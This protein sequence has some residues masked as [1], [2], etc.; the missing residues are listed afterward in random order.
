[1]RAG[2]TAEADRLSIDTSSPDLL[3]LDPWG[4]E[5]ITVVFA[6]LQF[7]RRAELERRPFL[8]ISCCNVQIKETNEKPI[9]VLWTTLRALDLKTQI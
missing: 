8:H 9:S 7:L 1:M 5:P 2:L 6:R 4:I 3:L